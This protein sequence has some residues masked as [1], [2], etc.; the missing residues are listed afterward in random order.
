MI[1]LRPNRNLESSPLRMSK[2]QTASQ[3]SDRKN[4]SFAQSIETLILGLA[5]GY[6]IASNEDSNSNLSKR[7]FS[8]GWIG[9]SNPYGGYGFGH[10]WAPDLNPWGG[11]GIKAS[12]PLETSGWQYG[13]AKVAS[14]IKHETHHVKTVP[15]VVTKHVVVEKPVPVKVPEP[16]LVERPVHVPV[17]RVIPVP[18]DRIITRPVPVAVPIP[19]AVPVPIEHAVPFPNHYGP[20]GPYSGPDHYHSYRSSDYGKSKRSKSSTLDNNIEQED[21][22]E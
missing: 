13:S 11:L 19:Q 15:V 4:Y 1:A 9:L 22:K 3:R 8:D 18:I 12:L 5:C 10:P 17:D 2:N 14:P 16:V 20:Y 6:A 7:S 21:D